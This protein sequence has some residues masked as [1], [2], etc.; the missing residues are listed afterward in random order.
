MQPADAALPAGPLEPVP[1]VALAQAELRV[2]L[3]AQVWA[4]ARAQAAQ[5]VWLPARVALRVWL[6]ARVALRV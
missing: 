2:W 1:A 3:P 4:L 6:P 5:R